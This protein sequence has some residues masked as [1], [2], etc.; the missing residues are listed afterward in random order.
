[1]LLSYLDRKNN[2]YSL[3]SLSPRIHVCEPHGFFS[4]PFFFSCGETRDRNFSLRDL[5]FNTCIIVIFLKKIYYS[6]NIIL[7]KIFE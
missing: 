5:F 2:I 7:I 6:I 1:M 3:S 4:F